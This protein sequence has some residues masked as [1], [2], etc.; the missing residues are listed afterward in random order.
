MVTWSTF[1]RLAARR[2]PVGVLAGAV[3]VAA[4]TGAIE[5]FQPWVP[6]LA[7]GVLYLFAV[8]P[9]AVLWGRLFAIGV[10]VASMLALNWFFLP[11]VHVHARGPRELQPGRGSMAASQSLAR[12]EAR[13]QRRS[14]LGPA[15]A[16]SSVCRYDRPLRVSLSWHTEA[17]VRGLQDHTT[18]PGA[19]GPRPRLVHRDH[20]LGRL[21]PTRRHRT[22]RFSEDA[23]R[24]LATA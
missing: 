21:R 5:L 11:P 15:A 19:P 3:A 10:S 13:T 18:R 24:G 22:T 2:W 17:L 9:I 1:E 12:R 4:V 16:R 14:A 8:L 7:L 23:W 6:V 20:L